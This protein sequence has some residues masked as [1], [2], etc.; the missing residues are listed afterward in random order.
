MGTWANILINLLNDINKFYQ[1]IE[2]QSTCTPTK[3]EIS[4]NIFLK[5]IVYN[6][7]VFLFF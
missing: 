1:L 2:I 5:Q 4:I 6:H 7:V 3:I